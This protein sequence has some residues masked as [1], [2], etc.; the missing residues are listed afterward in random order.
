MFPAIKRTLIDSGEAEY[1]TLHFPLERLHPRALKAA[2]AAECAA[3]QGKYWEMHERLFADP[4]ALE[5]EEFRSHAKTLNL[6]ADRFRRCI[7]SDE[8]LGRIRAQRT[9]G[10]RLGVTGTPSFF[11]GTVRADGGVDV[12]RRIAGAASLDVLRAQVAALSPLRAESR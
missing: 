4:K 2:E 9:E 3:A 6:D 1:A 11:L 5:P 8:T 10:M 12:L 7:E